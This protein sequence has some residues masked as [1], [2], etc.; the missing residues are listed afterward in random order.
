VSKPIINKKAGFNY[1]FLEK[2]EAGMVLQGSEVRSLREGRANLSDAYAI[3]RK[4]ELW[5][6]NCHISPYAPASYNNHEPT[7]SRKL[8]LKSD[9]IQRLIGKMQEKGLAL[10]PTK[11][12]FG[13]SGYA[14][15]QLALAQGK[16]SHDK[17][18]TIK[19]R[20]ADRSMRRALK[21]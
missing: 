20:E 16:A 6:L 17:R 19:K 21:R 18:A 5:L 10:I 2:F 9:E 8:L 11:L 12:Y 15:C 13:A 7:R 1:H 4:G 14:K 3:V